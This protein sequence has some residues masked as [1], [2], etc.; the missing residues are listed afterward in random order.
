[1]DAANEL[2][3]RLLN[4]IPA[5]AYAMQVLLRLTGIEV[6]RECPTARVTCG[7][8][9][10]LQVNPEFVE[11]HC[12]S[13][14][15]LF[16]LVMHEMKHVL[17]GHTRLFPTI[18]PAHNIAFDAVINADLMARFPGEAYASIFLDLYGAD[19]GVLRILAPPAPGTAEAP[20]GP[21]RELHGLLYS[22]SDVTA[23]EVFDRLV[24]AINSTGPEDSPGNGPLDG[25]GRLLGNHDA[26]Q[27]GPGAGDGDGQGPA[28]AQRELV[29][30]LE[31]LAA[32]WPGNAAGTGQA[33]GPGGDMSR[34]RTRPQDPADLVLATLRRAQSGGDVPRRSRQRRL[35]PGVRPSLGP[36]PHL[37]D[38][39]AVTARAAG[40]PVLLYESATFA[41]RL[42]V[43]HLTEIYLD[44][45]GSVHGYLPYLY[46]ALLRLSALVPD[47]L[48][49]FST[50]VATIRRAQL[51]SGHVMSTGGTSIDCVLEHILRNGVRRGLM[52][53]DGFVGKPDERL[54]ERVHRGRVELRA[55][56]TAGGSGSALHHVVREWA[57]LPDLKGSQARPVRSAS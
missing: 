52:I 44:V 42:P 41:P 46:G 19:T 24:Q 15:H 9:S 39:R 43:R 53:T 22:T 17:L 20:E 16:L 4:A 32:G 35:A 18:T 28:D 36:V 25:N 48:H 31:R 56:V 38:R 47:R 51:M 33:P 7:A 6:T 10:K 1:M 12:G 5:R 8:R 11:K 55:L 21:L 2:K 50:R 14:E 26:T 54:L 37:R 57:W 34:V 29:E 27:P 45:S 23:R 30:E 13:D 40:A 3:H 49:L